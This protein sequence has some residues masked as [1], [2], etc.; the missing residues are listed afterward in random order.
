MTEVFGWFEYQ[1]LYDQMLE[2]YDDCKFAEVGCFFG[3]SAIYLGQRIEG[4]KKNIQVVC[5]DLWPNK[6]ELECFLP[7]ADN[8]QLGLEAAIASAY[9]SEPLME[10]FINNVNRAGVRKHI[11]PVRCSSELAPEIFPDGFF[12]FIFIDAGHG[13][14]QVMLDLK[15]WYRKLADGGTM[16]GH[17][18]WGEV[19]KAVCEFF[20]DKGTITSAP[21]NIWVF[22][23]ENNG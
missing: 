2:K 20:R 22:S 19:E 1:H 15:A 9:T 17:D 7:A 14:E 23:G 16:A 8:G 4:L 11:F 18:Y 10:T 3:K 5:V 21:G 13:Y 6:E 12:K